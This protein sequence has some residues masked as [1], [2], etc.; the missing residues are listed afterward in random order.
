MTRR[1]GA[2]RKSTNASTARP[3]LVGSGPFAGVS[4]YCGEKSPGFHYI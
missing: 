3:P 2:G 4:I 1:D